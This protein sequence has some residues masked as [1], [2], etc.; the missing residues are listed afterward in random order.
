MSVVA[1]KSR[2]V[3]PGLSALMSVMDGDAV[4]QRPNVPLP[5]SFSG[6]SDADGWYFGDPQLTD[7]AL[8]A[9]VRKVRISFIVSTASLRLHSAE[10]Q[11]AA[12]RL[13]LCC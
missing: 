1:R 3:L 12:L 2:D 9:V 13:S 5:T 6:G 7:D 10:R 11:E 8:C 4:P